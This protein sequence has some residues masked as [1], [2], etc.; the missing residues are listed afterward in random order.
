MLSWQHYYA[1]SSEG[2]E[3]AILSAQWLG[4]IMQSCWCESLK[5]IWIT[6]TASL[7]CL[8]KHIYTQASTSDF[9]EREGGCLNFFAT[10]FVRSHILHTH[11]H[12]HQRAGFIFYKLSHCWWSLLLFC[13][14]KVPRTLN[15][16]AHAS[17]NSPAA[18]PV[19]LS[20]PHVTL[21]AP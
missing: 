20:V 9:Q 4:C 15:E 5:T 2:K 10:F 7:K 17:N 12:R 13:I 6:T 16:L 21:N 18:K 14:V 1:F 3:W 11:E 19:V 8:Q